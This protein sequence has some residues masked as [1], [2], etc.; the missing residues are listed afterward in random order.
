MRYTAGMLDEVERLYA[1]IHAFASSEDSELVPRRVLPEAL[2]SEVV[3]L[4]QALGR[5]TQRLSG[6]PYTLAD[7]TLSRG[8]RVLDGFLSKFG[9]TISPDGH[10]QYVYSTDLVCRYPGRKARGSGD[11]LP[12]PEEIKESAP[13]LE[14]E[15]L[16]VRPRV[17]VLLGKAAGLTFLA[18][19][20]G[21]RATSLRE[22]AGTPHPAVISDLEVTAF[23]VHHPSGAFQ[24]PGES[25]PLY[26]RTAAQIRS[27]LGA[28]TLRVPAID[29]AKVADAPHGDGGTSSRDD[30]SNTELLLAY[31]ESKSEEVWD[32][33]RRR[34][35]LEGRPHRPAGEYA[36]YLIREKYGG[37]RI[38]TKGP[39]HVASAAGQRI[40]VHGR[41]VRGREPMWFAVQFRLDEREFD[42]Y[43]PVLFDE[44]YG[45]RHAWQMP[46]ETLKLYVKRYAGT[47]WRLPVT[48]AWRD[49]VESIAL[50]DRRALQ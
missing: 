40:Q 27:F 17:V 14:A 37:H 35:V 39:Y 9:Y 32:E 18:R 13:W 28:D 50:P 6:L 49:E 47:G 3:I 12:G 33:L 16:L 24:F 26:E 38:G 15:L 4:G 36:A 29:E 46:W 25:G 22:V 34:G 41:H 23:V 31:E 19:Y 30:R 42:I 44:R 7:G 10:R 48:G 21:M 20:S 5:D 45:V 8:G 1:E 11:E 43:A 2:E